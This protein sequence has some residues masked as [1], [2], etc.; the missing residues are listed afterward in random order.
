LKIL[1]KSKTFCTQFEEELVVVNLVLSFQKSHSKSALKL[2]KDEVELLI[3]ATSQPYLQAELCLAWL[4]LCPEHRDLQG[5]SVRRRAL[6]A[7]EIF[8]TQWRKFLKN[9]SAQYNGAI[10][11]LFAYIKTLKVKNA[12]P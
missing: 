8:S 4:T 11:V 3:L 1:A 12:D 6:A 10:K 7:K 2:S 9:R 5:P